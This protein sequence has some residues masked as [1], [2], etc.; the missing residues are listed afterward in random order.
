M[1]RASSARAPSAIPPDAGR[2]YPAAGA[3]A[4]RDGLLRIPRAVAADRPAPLLVMLHGAR[5]TAASVMPLVADA[6]EA[7]GVVVLAPIRAAPPGT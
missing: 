7:H 6:A 4:E 3:G 2:R 5:S 1:R